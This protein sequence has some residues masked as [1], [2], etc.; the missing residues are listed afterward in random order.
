VSIQGETPDTWPWSVTPP[1]PP[2]T[3]S[4]W[5]GALGDYAV[6]CGDNAPG[7]PFNE[8]TA[9]GAFILGNWTG[10]GTPRTFT[11]FSSN[12]RFDSISDG[13]SNTL[14]VGEKHVPLGKFGREDAGD[15]PIYNGDPT[16]GNAARIAGPSNPIARAPT[17]PFNHQFGSYHAATCNFLL[18]DGSV[19][20]VG[21]T[22]SG[23]TLSRLSVRN[24]GLPVGDF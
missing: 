23:T 7:F 22:L 6:S 1:V 20:A 21:N 2:D 18:G 8:V 13:L 17:E 5:F 24:D 10:S 15:G 4:S 14:F 19:R 16:N 11:S 12:T 3:G 9:N